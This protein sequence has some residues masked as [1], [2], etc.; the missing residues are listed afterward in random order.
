MKV[1]Q[2]QGKYIDESC[3]EE[4]KYMDES[5]LGAEKYMYG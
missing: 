3:I 2:E 5:C 4:D 1:V